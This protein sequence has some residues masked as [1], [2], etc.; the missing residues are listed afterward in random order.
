MVGVQ[1]A[2]ETGVWGYKSFTEKNPFGD[3]WPGGYP[4]NLAGVCRP[5]PDPIL[6]LSWP[7]AGRMLTLNCGRM[8]ALNC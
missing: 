4:A 8:M 1:A 3:I 7:C 6:A 5:Y 2:L